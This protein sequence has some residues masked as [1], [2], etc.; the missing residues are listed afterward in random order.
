[1]YSKSACKVPL[2]LV[3]F[4]QNLNSLDSFPKNSNTSNFMK[5]R[6]V[7]ADLFYADERTDKTKPNSRSSQFCERA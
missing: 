2:I 1:M 5:S 7:G 3:R 6:P 4:E